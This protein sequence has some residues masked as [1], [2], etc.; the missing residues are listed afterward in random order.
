MLRLTTMHAPGSV[1]QGRPHS[2]SFLHARVR[3]R[4]TPPSSA[5]GT[6]SHRIQL[7]RVDRPLPIDGHIL[8]M[9][10]LGTRHRRV[11]KSCVTIVF[12]GVFL[13]RLCFEVGLEWF[14]TELAEA[15]AEP[16]VI[17]ALSLQENPIHDSLW[18][19]LTIFDMDPIVILLILIRPGNLRIRP[20][21]A[22]ER[23][24]RG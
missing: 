2:L 5:F 16:F 3:L 19:R 12:C 22:E 20:Y 13:L 24:L 21:P 15:S 18:S 11:C 17:L 9:C 10:W 6:V 1:L 7:A 23:G 8:G 4:W 14:E